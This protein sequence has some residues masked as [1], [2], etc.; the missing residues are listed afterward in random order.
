MDVNIDDMFMF[1]FVFPVLEGSTVCLL[2]CRR[3][4]GRGRGR[5]RRSVGRR[6]GVVASGL[7]LWCWSEPVIVWFLAIPILSCTMP[8]PPVTASKM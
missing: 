7:V 8:L 2:C 4:R 1:A 5:C 6:G 3:G